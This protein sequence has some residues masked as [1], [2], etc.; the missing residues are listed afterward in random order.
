[1]RDA[2]LSSSGHAQELRRD[3][4]ATST[5]FVA[6]HGADYF[7]GTSQ[8]VQQVAQGT[9]PQVAGTHT[10]SP[11]SPDR[12][13]SRSG[14]KITDVIASNPFAELH[15]HYG[16]RTRRSYEPSSVK[17][18]D[19]ALQKQRRLP[20][21]GSFL[22][23]GDGRAHG[24]DARA[25]LSVSTPMS[26]VAVALR[27]LPARAIRSWP[28]SHV[29]RTCRTLES[30]NNRHRT[31]LF[32]ARRSRPRRLEGDAP[33]RSRGCRSCP[34]AMASLEQRV[35]SSA[36]PTST[37]TMRYSAYL[38]AALVVSLAEGP[39]ASD[40][41]LHNAGACLLRRSCAAERSRV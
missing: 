13:I 21:F 33:A 17:T 26:R 12:A 8:S 23:I 4:Y 36:L 1:M 16:P 20:R 25:R 7:T 41:P 10:L 34:S 3:S 38:Q 39:V 31:R 40:L 35:N 37:R 9:Q 28:G 27:S 6:K 29:E 32:E 5:A 11:H 14:C 24:A 15:R 22:G 2:A 19:A 18:V 30:R